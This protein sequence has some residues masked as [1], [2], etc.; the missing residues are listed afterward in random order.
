MKS[1]KNQWDL[2]HRSMRADRFRA[3]WTKVRFNT[4]TSM[5]LFRNKWFSLSFFLLWSLF[6]AI[7]LAAEPV[8]VDYVY[9]GD[10]IRLR[11]GRRVRLI[12][13]NAPEIQH[14]ER[15]GRIKPGEKFGEE[16]R[17]YLEK[18]IAHKKVLLET[19][20]E[21]QDHY[22]RIL[23]YVFFPTERSSMK[24]WFPRG[25]RIACT[26][27]RMTDMQTDSFLHSRRQCGQGRGSGE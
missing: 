11:D 5:V 4:V 10:T 25:L 9:D 3:C 15:S 6:A 26:N 19:D 1:G 21:K 20:Q 14:T 7:S 13:I 17:Q 8:E 18:R 22:H 27:A 16:A 24:K 23:A 12:G 2:P